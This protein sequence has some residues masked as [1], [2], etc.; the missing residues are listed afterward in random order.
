MK[1]VAIIGA[2]I[3][4]LAAAYG[5]NKKGIR[6]IVFEKNQTIG[7]VIQSF[8]E[9]GFLA[10][11]GPNTMRVME[12]DIESLLNE[13]NIENEIVDPDPRIKKRFIVR[14]GKPVSIP[15]SPLSPF[16][17]ASYFIPV[18]TTAPAGTLY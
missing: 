17:N 9:K 3:T 16:Y 4:G 13:L 14:N 12:P 15:L 11:A 8:H 18:K 7:G 2:G 10:E 5:L 1:S 6:V